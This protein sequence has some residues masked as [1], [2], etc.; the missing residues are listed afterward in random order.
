MKYSRL[1]ILGG[2]QGY[3]P[4]EI[5]ENVGLLECISCILEQE[6]GYWTEQETQITAEITQNSGKI[7]LFFMNKSWSIQGPFS[8]ANVSHVSCKLWG[9]FSIK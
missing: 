9:N 7:L 2:I 6:L 8:V 5:L 4:L 3:S 1:K